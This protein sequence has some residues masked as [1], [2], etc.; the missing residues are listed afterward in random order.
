MNNV[1][2]RCANPRWPET[3]ICSGRGECLATLE[4]ALIF[5]CHCYE[6]WWGHGDAINRDGN[7]CNVHQQSVHI[8]HWIGLIYGIFLI[9]FLFISLY[10]LRHRNISRST[11]SPS[12]NYNH[13]N[14]KEANSPNGG[15]A[16]SPNPKDPITEAAAVGTPLRTPLPSPPT[17]PMRNSGGGGGGGVVGVAAMTIGAP[18]TGTA[19]DAQLIISMTGRRSNQRCSFP[20]VSDP[21]QRAVLLSGCYALIEIIYFALR[22]ND[23]SMTTATHSSIA[24]LWTVAATLFFAFA[25]LFLWIVV[26]SVI[27]PLQ[28]SGTQATQVTKIT[29]VMKIALTCIPLLC[30]VAI[31][32]LIFASEMSETIEEGVVVWSLAVMGL[33]CILVVIAIRI[34]GTR[35]V[36]IIGNRINYLRQH[37]W[38]N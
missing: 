17:G 36:G 26:Q 38:V 34:F 11:P 2:N 35:L 7:D 19:N 14:M 12:L 32:P 30:V 29:R 1:T 28:L 4:N 22:V 27:T 3:R 8:I 33:A 21:P 25:S 23:Q 18:A 5:E 20:Q 15:V 37:E 10:R 31:F 16:V 9:L 13:N 24:A 6:G